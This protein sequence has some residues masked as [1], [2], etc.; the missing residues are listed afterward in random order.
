MSKYPLGLTA[1]SLLNRKFL[2]FVTI[3]SILMGVLIL[4]RQIAFYL[5]TVEAAGT[6]GL[7]ALDATYTQNFD[8]LAN[9]GTSSTV[10]A[11][12]DFSESGTNGNTTYSAGTGSGNT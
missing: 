12:W 5:P 9:T 11:G 2:A 10:P 6:A 8:T 4:P 1:H 7:A 3:F